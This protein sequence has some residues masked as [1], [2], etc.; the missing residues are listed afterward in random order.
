[1]AVLR[2]GDRQTETHPLLLVIK[3]ARITEERLGSAME[4]AACLEVLAAKKELEQAAEIRINE[5]KRVKL[6]SG[7]DMGFGIS[8]L[9]LGL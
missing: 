9:G 6:A 5:Q 4:C 8:D 7:S 2:E 1:M 3:E